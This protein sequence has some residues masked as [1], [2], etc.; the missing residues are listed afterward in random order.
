VEAVRVKSS[1]AACAALAVLGGAV[2]RLPAQPA[3]SNPPQSQPRPTPDWVKIIDQGRYDPRLKGYLADE[4]IKVEIV[5]EHPVVTNP[6]GL[7]FGEDGTLYV[8]EWVRDPGGPAR[9]QTATVRYKDGTA[10]QTVTLGKQIKDRVKVLRDTRGAGVYDEAKV[11]L[12]DELPSGILRHD[13]W[14]YLAGRGSVRRYKQSQPGGPYD[15]REVVA[16]GF[17]GYGRQQISGMSIGNDGW[18]YLTAGGGDNLAEGSDGSRATVLRSG[19]VFRCRPDGSRLQVYSLGYCN[20]YGPVAFDAAGNGFHA[21]NGADDRSKFAGCRLIYVAEGSDLGWRLRAGARCCQPDAVR[22]A[23][24][25]E[26]PGRMPPLLRTGRGAASGLLVYNDTLLPEVYR[27]LLLYPDAA[28]KRIRASRTERDG[29]TFKVTEEFE[30]LKSDDAHFHPCQMV[31]GPDRAI[32]VCDSGSDPGGADQLGGDGRHGRI[33]R[34]TLPGTKEQPAVPRRGL[35]SWAKIND[36]G[37]DDLLK[38]LAAEDATDRRQAQRALVRKGESVRPGLLK[39]LKDADAPLPARIAALGALESLWNDDVESAFLG[40]LRDGAA[41]VRRLA[42][43]GLAL[44]CRPGDERAH[45]ALLQT[46]GDPEPAVRRAVFLAMGQVGGPGAADDLVN[47]LAFD[48][49]RDLYLRDGLVRAIERLG[50]EG[51]GRLVALAESGDDRNLAKVVA[52]F[53]GLRTRPAADAIPGLLRNPHLTVEQ[54]AGLV[55]SY[56]NYLLDPPVD[57]RPLAEYLATNPD[58]PRAVRL[59]ALQVFGLDGTARGTK[60]EAW[61]RAQLDADDSAVVRGAVDALGAQPAGA[62][63]LARRFL[64]RKLPAELRDAVAAVLARHA[65]DHPELAR[66]LD[67]VK[68]RA[69]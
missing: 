21:D 16:Q 37:E 28:R 48:D 22:G 11:I 63:D 42:A 56:A 1:L 26:L 65:P 9:E 62:E 52:A 61:L 47:A 33:Y 64:D 29:A 50:K 60:G 40:R 41:D 13:G 54:R 24:S 6:V 67:A 39:L 69:K 5:A 32:Y 38:T 14:L 59:D 4:Q 17:C 15:V 25:G 57:L 8:L 35:D 23:A 68:K 53:D 49:G 55:R 18:L 30:F 58:E 31:V 66:L 51:I 3:D 12:E 36:L 46:L 10:R 43:D 7:T 2:L 34:V 27:G 20:P 44:H 19:A 45:D